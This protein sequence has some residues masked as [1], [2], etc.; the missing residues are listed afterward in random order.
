[1]PSS[2]KGFEQAY[3]AQASVDTEMM[4]I[5]TSH[6]SQATNDKKEIKPTLDKLNALPDEAG[7]VDT[8]I[9][10]AGYFSD[11][12]TH[13]CEHAGVQPLIA[14]G[15]EKHH[16]SFKERFATPA[17]VADDA[18]AVT[19][20]KHRLKTSEGR[21]LYAKRKCTVEPVFG[22]IKAVLG[23]R[24]FLLRGMRKVSGEWNLV[25]LAYNLKRM[26]VLVSS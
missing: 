17:P 26:H 2:G 13:E 21:Q 1:M 22:V 5:V 4:L 18:D 12:N 25:C 7:S 6:V 24:Q 16:Q 14:A 9:A 19:R 15:R 23:F 11:E 10:D 3:N 20:M 8:L